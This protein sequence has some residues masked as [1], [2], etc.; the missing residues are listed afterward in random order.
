LV[1][2]ETTIAKKKPKRLRKTK[3]TGKVKCLRSVL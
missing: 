1:S 3:R 2:K